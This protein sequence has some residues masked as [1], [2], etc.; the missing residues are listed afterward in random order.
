MIN[1]G[2]FFT[3][4]AALKAAQEIADREGK[5]QY[6]VVFKASYYLTDKKPE[7]DGNTTFYRIEG[8]VEPQG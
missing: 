1:E 7:H 4:D 8:I 3:L 5:T 6:V 2:P